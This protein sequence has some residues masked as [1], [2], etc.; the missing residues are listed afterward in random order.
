MFRCSEAQAAQS[1]PAM[2]FLAM[3]GPSH[4]SHLLNSE[5]ACSWDLSQPVIINR[6]E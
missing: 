3:P 6:P 1:L 5:A 2:F 4:H